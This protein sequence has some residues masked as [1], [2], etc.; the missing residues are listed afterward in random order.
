MSRIESVPVT[1]DDDRDK[2]FFRV[3]THVLDARFVEGASCLL[4][5]N[6]LELSASP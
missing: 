5:A 3:V 2:A 6:D 4:S 1:W